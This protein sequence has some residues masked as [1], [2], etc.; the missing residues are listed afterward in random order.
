[1]YKQKGNK[2]INLSF[3]FYLFINEQYSF[4]SMNGYPDTKAQTFYITTDIHRFASL[5]VILP[6]ALTTC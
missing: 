2:K 1:M 3:I 6:A 5:C 4:K